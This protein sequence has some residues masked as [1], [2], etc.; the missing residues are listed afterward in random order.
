MQNKGQLLYCSVI[1]LE[2]HSALEVLSWVVRK[3]DREEFL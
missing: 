3:A 2:K 1:D